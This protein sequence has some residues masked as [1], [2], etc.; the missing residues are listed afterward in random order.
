MIISY[1]TIRQHVEEPNASSFIV[2]EMIAAYRKAG[3][4]GGKSFPVT[5]A[6]GRS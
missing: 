3:S 4:E 6:T 2:A 1:R 5:H